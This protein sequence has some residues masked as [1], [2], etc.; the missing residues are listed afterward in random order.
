MGI[1]YPKKN[2][3]PNWVAFRDMMDHAPIAAT[4]I[5]AGLELDTSM[6]ERAIAT[7]LETDRLIDIA[8]H[9]SHGAPLYTMLHA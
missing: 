7:L 3:Y 9:D 8:G 4:A 5:A 6:V 2:D 1:N